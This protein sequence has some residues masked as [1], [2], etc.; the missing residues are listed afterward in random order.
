[1]PFP[2]PPRPSSPS[3]SPSLTPQTIVY[4][5][6]NELDLTTAASALRAGKLIAFPTETV[7]G[8]GADATNQAA[9][10]SIFAAK[11]RPADNPLI[12]HLP[13][14]QTLPT[15]TPTPLPAA[16]TRLIAAFWPGP[17]TLILPLHPRARLAAAVTAGLRSVAVRVPRHPVAAALLSRAGVPVAA[18]SANR[19]GRP[20]PTTAA[21][22]LCDLDGAV[23]GVV[24]G[25]AAFG[26]V[27]STVVDVRGGMVRVL[28]PGMV[29]VAEIERVIGESVGRAG[30]VEPG[31]KVVAPGMKYRHY[32]PGAPL[33]V[34]RAGEL[35][36][37]IARWEELG[38]TVGVLAEAGVA[39]RLGKQVRAVTCGS[40]G[41]VESFAR[42]L[43]AALRAFDGEGTNAV[44]GADV[45][46][47]VPPAG[48]GGLLDAVLNRLEKA[49]A[50][51]GESG[52][53]SGRARGA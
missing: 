38:Q 33:Y 37:E 12:V 18:P 40:N 13:S 7:Y 20:S 28:R 10:L 11:H 17:L 35:A 32:A 4:S 1:M 30:K 15:L 8:L 39:S 2:P 42:E 53:T 24:D 6:Q 50:G 31:E 29:S 51:N 27:E 43:Y 23:D 52:V 41:D 21:H 44:A 34:V 36:G 47:A 26:G 48:S 16:A 14:A 22:V 45:I 49:A 9:V 46:L 3:P 5:G 25:G 19:S